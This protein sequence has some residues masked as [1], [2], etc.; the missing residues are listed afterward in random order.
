VASA[1]RASSA[2][3]WSLALAQFALDLVDKLDVQFE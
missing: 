3:V 1:V 2:N